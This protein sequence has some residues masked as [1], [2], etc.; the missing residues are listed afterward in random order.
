[1]DFCH[2]QEIY[3][4]NMGKKLTDTATKTGLNAASTTSKKIIH[5]VVEVAGELIG[6]KIADKIVKPK[7]MPS[8]KSRDVEEIVIS[9]KEKKQQQQKQN[10]KY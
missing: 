9:P 8:A 1:M 7:P 4:A 5:K 2:L 3:L 6:N 10:E